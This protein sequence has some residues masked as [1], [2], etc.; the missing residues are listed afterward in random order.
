MQTYIHSSY[1]RLHLQNRDLKLSKQQPVNG[2][3]PPGL[4]Q[5]HSTFWWNEFVSHIFQNVIIIAHDT[6]SFN[7]IHCHWEAP[8]L[9]YMT[10]YF[11]F[12]RWI[13]SLVHFY[14]TQLICLCAH[15]S[16]DVSLDSF[17]EIFVW[18]FFP[19]FPLPMEFLCHFPLYVNNLILT[20][21]SLLLPHSNHPY[22]KTTMMLLFTLS[23][24]I[25]SMSWTRSIGILP[26]T[27]LSST[28]PHI[29]IFNS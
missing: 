10:E 29:H 23:F 16:L 7:L 24:L 12:L 3:S 1:S 11:L 20:Q 27:V 21:C 17:S 8:M 22:H 6:T 19:V 18:Y 14:N 13:N 4:G 5:H 28:Y 2:I 25:L 15:F 26:E 9:Q